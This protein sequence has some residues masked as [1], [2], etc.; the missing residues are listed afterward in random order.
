MEMVC[1]ILDFVS[2]DI[3]HIYGAYKCCFSVVVVVV[4]DDAVSAAAVAWH[5][6]TKYWQHTKYY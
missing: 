6:S 5:I 2:P 4:Y 1:S 3:S